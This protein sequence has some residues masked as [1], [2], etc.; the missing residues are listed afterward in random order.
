ML[1]NK[2]RCNFQF[3]RLT[4]IPFYVCLSFNLWSTYWSLIFSLACLLYRKK[5][6]VFVFSNFWSLKSKFVEKDLTNQQDDILRWFSKFCCID[7]FIFCCL[8]YVFASQAQYAL[9]NW[10]IS[11]AQISLRQQFEIQGEL[12]IKT[13]SP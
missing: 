2:W 7:H 13:L 6:G 9:L 12:C 3:I 8:S 1:I 10:K 4:I 5:A 11:I